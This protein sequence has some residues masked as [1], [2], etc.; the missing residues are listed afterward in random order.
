M[1]LTTPAAVRAKI[2]EL[3]ATHEP[4]L[5][6][7][8]LDA[9]QDAKDTIVLQDVIDALLKKDLQAAAAAIG[10]DASFLA[11]LD[12]A[13][14]R[15][16]YEGGRAFNEMVR[17]DGRRAGFTLNIRFDPGQPST[18]AALRLRS[19]RLITGI[20]EEQ[21]QAVR[22]ALADGMSAGRH[23]RTVALDTIGRVNKATG[24]REGGV[25]GLTN[26]QAGYVENARRELLSGNKNQMLAY[27][28]RERRDRRYDRAVM[29][30]IREGRAVSGA[31][32]QKIVQR[33]S[34]R[35]LAYRAEVIARTESMSA[36]SE[37]QHESM[38]Q[39]ITAGEL[40]ADQ[41]YKTWGGRL[42]GRTR[43]THAALIGKTIPY[44]E[45]FTSPSGARMRFPRDASLGAGAAE[46]IQCRCYLTQSVKFGTN[47]DQ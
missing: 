16:F 17:L 6:Q 39:F 34:D 36:L 15:T 25:I 11:P 21:R 22:S 2:E 42:D 41:L 33:Y 7:A 38:G 20:V 37:A 32:A 8:F 14:S 44:Q 4:W 23:P 43:D 1:P 40:R 13:A 18:A 3:L 10:M 5:R 31:D 29:Q 24:K 9:I 47:S 30:A 45:A 26:A 27:L 12:M 35:L 46:I 28:K 19:S